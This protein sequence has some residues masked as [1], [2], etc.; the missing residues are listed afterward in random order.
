MA[1]TLNVIKEFFWMHAR[2]SKVYGG[3][4]NQEYLI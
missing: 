2:C 1:S 4:V 3:L